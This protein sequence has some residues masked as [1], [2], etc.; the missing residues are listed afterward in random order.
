[1]KVIKLQGGLS[2][3]VDDSDFESLSKFKWRAEKT[4]KRDSDLKIIETFVACR[5]VGRYRILMHRQ[6]AGLESNDGM[7]CVHRDGDG[8][9]NQKSNLFVF[10]NE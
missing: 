4:R 3:R 8:L 7:R 6:I 1:M 2:A 10:A 5:Y 9:N